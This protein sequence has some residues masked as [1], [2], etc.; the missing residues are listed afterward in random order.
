MCPLYRRHTHS[1]SHLFTHL[2]TYT[3][4]DTQSLYLLLVGRSQQLHRL[5]VHAFH[6]FL[7]VLGAAL[8][9]ASPN[10]TE[11]DAQHDGTD[12][13]DD[14]DQAPRRNA[15]LFGQLGGHLLCLVGNLLALALGRRR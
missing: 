14:G 10:A 1:V 9:T 7:A 3:H 11:Q 6:T 4:T 13:N 2:H 15:H 5:Q 8:L 12:Q